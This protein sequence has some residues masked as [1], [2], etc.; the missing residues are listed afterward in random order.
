MH[1]F[2]PVFRADIVAGE[3]RQVDRARPG[4]DQRAALPANP[5][6]QARGKLGLGPFRILLAIHSFTQDV[7]KE[8]EGK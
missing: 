7:T 6:P 1:L 5:E 4:P 8:M 2:V 3:A